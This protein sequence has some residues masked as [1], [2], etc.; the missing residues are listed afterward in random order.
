[1]QHLFNK[2]LRLVF[3]KARDANFSYLQITCFNIKRCALGEKIQDNKV[4][5]LKS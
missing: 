1:M 2:N 5:C 4:R 3:E